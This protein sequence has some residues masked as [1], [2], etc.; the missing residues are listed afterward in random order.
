MHRIVK[1]HLDGFVS[2]FGLEAESE[3]D[4]FEKFCAH[5]VIASRYAATFDLDDVT[6][7][8]GDDGIDGIAIIIDEEVCVSPEDA[9]D[10]FSTPRRNHDV[11]VVFVQAKRSENFDLGDFLKFKEAILR[12]ATQTPYLVEDECL[13]NARRIFDIVVDNVPKIRNGKPSLVARFTTTGVYKDPPAFETS[14]SDFLAQ[15]HELG[16]FIDCDVK[17]IDREKLTQLWVGTYSGVS[18][19]LDLFSNGICSTR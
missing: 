15:L 17:F 12:F 3:A 9:R 7:G 8:T 19:S 2:N 6:T 1:A 16:L 18:A 14:K 13:R 10:A 5:C 11:D 4:Q